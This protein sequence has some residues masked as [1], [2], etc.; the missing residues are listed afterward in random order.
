MNEIPIHVVNPSPHVRL[1]EPITI[2][3]PFARGTLALFGAGQSLSSA[4][5]QPVPLQTS[6]LAFWPD[7]SIKWL[8]CDFLAD[9]AADGES[10]FYLLPTAASMC[11]E[12]P[13]L[14]ILK[15]PK[16]WIIDTGAAQFHIAPDQFRPFSNVILRNNPI[17]PGP[18]RFG[19]VD[20]EG[21]SWTPWNDR[22]VVELAG[23]VRTVLFFSGSFKRKKKALLNYEARLHFYADSARVML[24]MRLHNPRAA[25]HPGNLW[26][27]GDS[28]SVLIKEWS[29]CLP[30]QSDPQTRSYIK[31]DKNGEWHDIS[32]HQG[33][34]LYQESSG[35]RNWNS[36]VHRDQTGSIPMKRSGWIFSGEG[37]NFSGDR[38]QPVL[39]VQTGLSTLTATIDHFW[40]RFPKE[41]GFQ[42]GNIQFGLLPGCFPAH[43]E[44][45]GGEQI[46]ERI[47]LDFATD[48]QFNYWGQSSLSIRCDQQHYHNT[49]VFPEG[50]WP[51]NN[52][53]YRQLLAMA[54]DNE[55]GFKVK[56]EQ[57]DEYGWRNFGELY[58]DHESAFNKGDNIFVSHYNNQYDP[59]YSFYRLYLTGEDNQWGEMARDLAAHLQDIDI[60]HTDQDR[61]EYNHGLFWHT[62]HYLDAGLSTHR[63]A[64][65]EHLQNKNPAF[66]GGGPGAEHCYSGGLMLHYLLTGDPRSKQLVLDL[67]DWCWISLHGPQTLGAAT[68]RAF[69]NIK[70]LISHAKER[71]PRYPFSRGTGNCLNTTLDAFEIT[72][73]PDYLVRATALV[74]GTIHH[75]DNPEERDLL[76][77]ESSWSY[78]VFLAA[79]GRYLAVKQMW[80][81]IDQDFSYARHSLLTYARWITK[82]EYPFLDKP[83]NLEYPNE[84][85]P[86]QDLR[87]GVVLYYAA[88]YAS[89]YDRSKFIN[90][91]KFFLEYGLQKLCSHRN[92]CYTR[93][94]VL[95]LQNGW[96][97]EAIGFDIQPIGESHLPE[98]DV[99]QSMHRYTVVE[100]LRRTVSDYK[101]VL[102][103]TGFKR[104][105][106]WLKARLEN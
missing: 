5:G 71:W 68:L 81:Q 94:L 50:L 48:E 32:V 75:Q 88:K 23:P 100:F 49:K 90:K 69:K 12:T 74:K 18:S 43:H 101:A 28:A 57:L 45:Q 47:L 91:A 98:L 46:T 52:A 82:H 6:V 37:Q 77:A 87:K 54:L 7:K 14:T 35:G 80:Q 20:A 24:E 92:S 16:K 19:L 76:N 102:A 31:I 39:Y 85:W 105:W 4:Q 60:N 17:L 2:G 30:I 33:G 38:S 25:L 27:L 93:P 79:L 15:A 106:R 40:Q 103:H 9:L 73:N 34:R 70:R 22:T 83:E 51:P 11:P 55:K 44:L 86:A 21:N 1:K 96:A 65:R 59:L 61:E 99:R 63:M 10:L 104:E 89:K 8:L 78:M 53:H 62:D 26:D 95:M 58:A 29:M 97:I 42:E 64:S 3:V 66:C 41:I 56:R 72:G 67:A 84:T 13:P 36:P